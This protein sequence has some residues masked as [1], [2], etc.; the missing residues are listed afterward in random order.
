MK[1]YGF[2]GE[3]RERGAFKLCVV[4]LNISLVLRPTPEYRKRSSDTWQAFPYV[5]SQHI[6]Y[7]KFT[8]QVA[9]GDG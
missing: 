1:K 6:P 3:E 9:V 4:P 8:W 2:S 7:H 5:L